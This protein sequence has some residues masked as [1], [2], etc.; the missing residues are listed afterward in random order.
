MLSAYL[1]NGVLCPGLRALDWTIYPY[2]LPFYRLFLSPHLTHLSL[3]YPPFGVEVSDEVLSGLT[4][5][6]LALEPLHLRSL[7]LRWHIPTEASRRLESAVS[8]AVLR[9]GPSLTTLSVSTSLL[10]AAAQH[11]THLPKLTFWYAMNGL[12]KGSNFSLS[13]AFPQL[14]YLEL[15]TEESL[16][17]IPLLGAIARHTPSGQPSSHGPGQSLITLNSLAYVRIDAAFMSPIA[18]FHGLVHLTLGSSC[19]ST[20]GC[21]FNLTDDDMTRIA[22]GLPRL[23]HARFGRVCSANSCRTTVSSLVSLSTRCRELGFLE[24]HFNTI[25]LRDDLESVLAD[26]RPDNLPPFPERGHFSL[27]LGDAPISITGEDVGP[28]LTGFIT[29][30]GPLYQIYGRTDGQRGLSSRLSAMRAT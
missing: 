24:V 12:P 26:P 21:A 2:S 9:C 4:S 3:F 25:N 29:I 30:F 7:S 22:T 27:S 14:E 19:S 20:G 28:V 16:E 18:E 17:W 6:I 11:I 15:V 10:D 8:S 1:P 5:V 23:R 13:N